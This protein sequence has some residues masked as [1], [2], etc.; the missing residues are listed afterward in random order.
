MTHRQLEALK[1]LISAAQAVDDHADADI[2]TDAP[3]CADAVAA[4]H[5]ALGVLRGAIGEVLAWI[6]E[7][8]PIGPPT[9]TGRQ[10]CAQEPLLGGVS[11][12][13][14]SIRT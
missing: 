14:P 11:D 3:E 8:R 5:D 4:L 9:A 13:D 1:A 7:A 10:N 6:P 2:Y 12:T